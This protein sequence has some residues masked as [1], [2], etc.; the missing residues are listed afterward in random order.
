MGVGALTFET[1]IAVTGWLL[2]ALA[3]ALLLRALVGD[4]ARGRRRCGKCWYDMAG[5]PGLTCPE[6]GRA[7]KRERGLGRSRRSRKLI[8]L[9]LMGAILGFSVSQVWFWKTGAFLD[10]VPRWA[11]AAAAWTQAERA[12]KVYGM[13]PTRAD[14]AMARLYSDPSL[15]PP[16]NL[17]LNTRWEGIL[18]C[19]QAGRVLDQY[20]GAKSFNSDASSMIQRASYVLISYEL[21]DTR[22]GMKPLGRAMWGEHWIEPLYVVASLAREGDAL[23]MQWLEDFVLNHHEARQRAAAASWL[24]SAAMRHPSA[25]KKLARVVQTPLGQEAAAAVARTARRDHEPERSLEVMEMLMTSPHATV[26][27]GGLI[28]LQDF[29]PI[30]RYEPLIWP[31]LLNDPSPA[32]RAAAAR[33]R[34]R[35][36]GLM[37]KW[38][39]ALVAAC[40][41]EVPEV[42]KAAMSTLAQWA[43]QAEWTAAQFA[44]WLRKRD[45]T[46]A[47]GDG[48]QRD[49]FEWASS[50]SMEPYEESLR[51]RHFYRFAPLDEKMLAWYRR[52]ALEHPDSS[53]RENAL[54]AVPEMRAPVVWHLELVAACLDSEA[55]ASNRAPAIRSLIAL[56]ET[57]HDGVQGLITRGLRDSHD[58]VRYA[59]VGLCVRFR[60]DDPECLA[61]LEDLATDSDPGL[62]NA[63]LRALERIRREQVQSE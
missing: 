14:R 1:I 11:L 34:W 57:D 8:A 19:W 44:S 48:L 61:A 53:V 12:E 9:A 47:L 32:V 35:P 58:Y 2:L 60:I 10:Y 51:A 24:C 63:A 38:G 17:N 54:R 59:A 28:G 25:M 41:D 30:P 56:V 49:P 33:S 43:S 26:R 20:A 21:S 50:R 15:N 7:H 6:C 5:V 45:E 40:E 16:I 13:A 55:E 46:R 22:M 36:Q 37:D 3:M 27:E 18:A 4:R 29:T 62:A 39:P 31:L 42:A 23:A 52:A